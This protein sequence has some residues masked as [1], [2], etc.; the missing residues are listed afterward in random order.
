MK[1]YLLDPFGSQEAGHCLLGTSVALLGQECFSS[2]SWEAAHL[3]EPFVAVSGESQWV[4]G[5]GEAGYCKA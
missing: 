2:E 1:S 4:W 5:I 3:L